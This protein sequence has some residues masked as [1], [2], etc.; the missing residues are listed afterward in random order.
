MR[1][2]GVII[3]ALEIVSLTITLQQ[4][5]KRHNITPK[6]LWRKLTSMRIRWSKPSKD[7]SLNNV[8]DISHLQEDKRNDC[9]DY[10]YFKK[11]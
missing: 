6:N 4:E 2:I 11:K 1:F 10:S 9:T 5:C 7:D 3:L 8:V